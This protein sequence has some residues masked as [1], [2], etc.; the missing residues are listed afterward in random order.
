MSQ[1]QREAVF[2]QV[3]WNS[4]LAPTLQLPEQLRTHSA[5]ILLEFPDGCFY[6]GQNY[7]AQQ[8]ISQDLISSVCTFEK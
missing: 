1:L 2:I 4:L 7:S 3:V 8:L 6:V 5:C